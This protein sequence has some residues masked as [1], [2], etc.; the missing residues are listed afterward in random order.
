LHEMTV[1]ILG[2]AFKGGSDDT[3]S[4]LSYKLK[5]ILRFKARDVLCHDPFVSSDDELL[6]LD[7]VLERSD[8]LVIGTPH[9]L[10]RDLEISVPMVDVWN[11]RM[12]S[13]LVS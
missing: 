8:L 2:M 12:G 9:D 10:Y 5:R 4:S 3:R 6:P 13:G 1:G 11:L 7:D